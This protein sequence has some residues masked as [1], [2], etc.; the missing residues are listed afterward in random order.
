MSTRGI[1][2]VRIDGKDKLT[3][4]H[5]DS[6]P[7]GL[8]ISIL[9]QAAHIQDVWGIEESKRLARKLKLVS[10]DIP[11][12][13]A[14]IAELMNF[15]NMG[16][17]EQSDADWYCL[18][19]E[20]QGKLVDALTIGYMEDGCDFIYDSLFCEWGYIVNL[21]EGVLEVYQGFQDSPHDKGR[22]AKLDG[23]SGTNGYEG[24]ALLAIFPLDSLPTEPEFLAEINPE[25]NE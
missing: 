11:P 24:C 8:G 20:L 9:E 4:N 14:E 21:D 6:Y 22:Y 10:N 15:S 13:A 18:L 12:T 23:V 5:F 25:D 3:Y 1:I 16:V 2:G 19:R 17:G 7:K